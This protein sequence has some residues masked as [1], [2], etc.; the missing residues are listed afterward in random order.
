MN[1]YKLNHFNNVARAMNNYVAVS[2]YNY[3]HPHQYHQSIRDQNVYLASY[4]RP[5]LLDSGLSGFLAYGLQAIGLP[6]GVVN[7]GYRLGY[8]F[9][10]Y[11]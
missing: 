7:F 9:D 11:A 5:G 2:T 6:Y 8:F 10:R 4:G 1:A 3:Y